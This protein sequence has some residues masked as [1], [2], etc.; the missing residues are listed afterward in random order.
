MESFERRNRQTN[1][2]IR[3]VPVEASSFQHSATD[4][5]HVSCLN[6][7]GNFEGATTRRSAHAK[8]SEPMTWCEGCMKAAEPK[9]IVA[10]A[11]PVVL[12]R[13]ERLRAAAA[14]AM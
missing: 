8:A 11:A 10:S 1:T 14:D 7:K 2:I 5:W 9:P 6:H 3:I 13:E 12:T 4:R